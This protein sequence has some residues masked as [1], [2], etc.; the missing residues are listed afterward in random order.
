MDVKDKIIESQRKIIDDLAECEESISLLYQKYAARFPAMRSQWESLVEAEHT[1]AKLLK[2][3]HRILDKGS[4]FFNIG[5][6]NKDMM[7]P[8]H[9]VIEDALA[10]AEKPDLTQQDATKSALSIESSLLDAH[11][12]DKVTSDAPEFKIIAERLSKETKKHV[13]VIRSNFS[14]KQ[15]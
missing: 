4:I 15:A 7:E 12:Y 1:H 10:A 13:E 6:F 11:F 14:L 5:K 2:S 8:V 9:K 3:M